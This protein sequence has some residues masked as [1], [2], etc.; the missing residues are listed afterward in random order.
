MKKKKGSHLSKALRGVTEYILV[1]AKNKQKTN[2]YGEPAYSDKWQPLA[3]KTNRI[4]HLSFEADVVE[5]KLSDGIHYPNSAGGYLE[6]SSAI[7]V[8]NGRVT[9][10][11]EV[12]GPFVWTQEKLQD[13]ILKIT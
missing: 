6:F 10:G 12:K 7:K 13:E 9:E 5:T 3:K 2:L 8:K 1:V 4:K 11:F